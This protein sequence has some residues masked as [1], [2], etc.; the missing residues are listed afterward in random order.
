MSAMA[1]D[2]AHPSPPRSPDPSHSATSIPSLRAQ[3]SSRHSSSTSRSDSVTSVNDNEVHS[4]RPGIASVLV[5][6]LLSPR[7]QTQIEVSTGVCCVESHSRNVTET[8]HITKDYDPLTGTKRINRYV[9]L[10][11]IGRGVHGKVKIAR[12]TETEE[13]VAIKIVKRESRRRLGRRNP[14]EAEQKI[15]REIAIMKKCV[16]PNVVALREV[17]DDPNSNKIYLGM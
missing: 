12:D 14:F 13:I 9:M 1:D 3:Y 16:H 7:T 17:M 11:T 15:R 8:H 4:P 2:L 10:E 5:N 6:K